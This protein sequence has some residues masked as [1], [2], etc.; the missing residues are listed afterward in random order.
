[1]KL[2]AILAFLTLSVSSEA[3]LKKSTNNTN[4][5]HNIQTP[6]DV[7]TF[8]T[9][10]FRKLSDLYKLKKPNTYIDMMIDV[11]DITAS[12]CP[13]NDASC[14][15]NVY[16]K[17]MQSYSSPTTTNRRRRH[18]HRQL[19]SQDVTTNTLHHTSFDA[20]VRSALLNM[21]D[22]INMADTLGPDEVRSRLSDIQTELRN[23]KDVDDAHRFVGLIGAS[24][25]MESHDLW[26]DAMSNEDHPFYDMR[27]YFDSEG[28]R[29]NRRHRSLKKTQDTQEDTKE[30]ASAAAGTK[31]EEAASMA[32]SASVM[33]ES[34][35]INGVVME[36][37]S[38]AVEA[39]YEI[40][41]H[42]DI[43][44]YPSIASE[45]LHAAIPASAHGFFVESFL[46]HD[47]YDYDY[48]SDDDDDKDH[49]FLLSLLLGRDDS[50]DDYEYDYRK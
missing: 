25:A 14:V 13:I 2:S 12:Y 49:G 42:G 9:D 50:D 35:E 39:A 41:D 11:A 7:G 31:T 1:M 15:S 26:F 43:F 17:T 32:A 21:H 20:N 10:A 38:A 19:L 36:D 46:Y 6:E 44:D 24:V 8:H 4:K 27:A 23:M 18:R 29:N 3:K 30:V 48:D 28:N 16:K 22:I 33:S 5:G 37:F 40:I 34:G 47:D 45:S